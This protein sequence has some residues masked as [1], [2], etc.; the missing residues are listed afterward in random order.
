MLQKLGAFNIHTI[1]SLSGPPGSGYRCF[2]STY[3]L[4]PVLTKKVH[5]DFTEPPVTKF[6]LN[7]SKRSNIRRYLRI[8]CCGA[9][10]WGLSLSNKLAETI[11]KK[12]QPFFLG[13][14]LEFFFS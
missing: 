4:L 7:A 14:A 11:G 1:F 6:K 9:E 12:K 5:K 10:R 3:K 8:F 13:A 2:Y